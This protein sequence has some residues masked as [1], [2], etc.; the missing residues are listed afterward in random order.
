MGSEVNPSY[1]STRSGDVRDSHADITR[2]RRVTGE[3][4]TVSFEEGLRQTL[5]R[6]HIEAATMR[7]REQPA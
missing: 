7:N 6:Y 3:K 2:A 4:P 1:G 5:E